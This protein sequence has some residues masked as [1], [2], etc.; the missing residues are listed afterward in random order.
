[1]HRDHLTALLNNYF[2]TDSAE[3]AYKNLMLEFLQSCSDCFERSCQMGHFTASAFL[4]NKTHDK[5]LLMHHAKLDRW[6]QPG[7]HCDGDSNT[8]NVAIKE[9]Q[10]ESG[11]E[12]ITAVSPEIFD[13][14]IHL[15]PENKK[16]GEHAHYHFDIRFLL[17]SETENFVLNRESKELKWFTS[18]ISELP[19]QS[20]SITRMFDKWRK[21]TEIIQNKTKE[22]PVVF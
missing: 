1:M 14:D 6:F 22:K 3:Q 19:N 8:L 18:D 15:I 2:P 16:R 21:R 13:I 20:P 11:I 12:Q 17:E 7:G 10:E 9:A 4:L 5:A